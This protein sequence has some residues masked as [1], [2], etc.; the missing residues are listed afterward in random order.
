M[1]K[2]LPIV[3]DLNKICKHFHKDSGKRS[4]P[5]QYTVIS[6]RLFKSSQ[7]QYKVRKAERWWEA[8]NSLNVLHGHERIQMWISPI[9]DQVSD[10]Y[11]ILSLKY[12]FMHSHFPTSSCWL[13]LAVKPVCMHAHY[14]CDSAMWAVR[15]DVKSYF[16]KR[17]CRTIT[18]SILQQ[19]RLWEL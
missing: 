13:N 16:F 11:A 19:A 10:H 5:F 9:L 7:K 3:L 18:P 4:P 12:N 8:P 14:V 17:Y 6:T 1:G 15:T 2:L